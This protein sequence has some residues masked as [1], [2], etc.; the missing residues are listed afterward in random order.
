[1]ST[2]NRLRLNAKYERL[3]EPSED[4]ERRARGGGIGF[5][6]GFADRDLN[7]SPLQLVDEGLIR[8]M[9]DHDVPATGGEVQNGAVLRDDDIEAGE[10]ARHSTQIGQPP[11]GYEDHHG[12][13]RRSSRIGGM[14]GGRQV[15]TRPSS[16]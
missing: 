12:A 14:S 7:A 4:V 10:V 9:A 5:D 1:V 3:L 2:I 15:A 11:S 16:R 8:R 13:L 6:D